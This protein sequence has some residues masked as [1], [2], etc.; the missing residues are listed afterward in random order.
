MND[1]ADSRLPIRHNSLHEEVLPLIRDMIV[2]GELEPGERISE[3][4]LCEQF[5][6]SRTPLREALKVLAAQGIIELLP[7]RGATVAKPSVQDLAGLLIII[8][9]LEALGG[10]IACSRISD[11][12]IAEIQSL[13]ERMLSHYEARH[14]LDYFKLNQQIHERIVAAA[15][16]QVLTDLHRSLN[17]RVGRARFAPVLDPG[18]WEKAVRE[19]G[20]IIEAL[21]MRDGKRLASILEAHLR[22]NQILVDSG[23]VTWEPLEQ[24]LPARERAG[25][26][27]QRK[28]PIG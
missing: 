27:A 23:N 6:I 3:A 10:E 12:E 8:S 7:R 25:A 16:V 17:I 26:G 21:E 19:H 15:D 20:Q 18:I 28:I 22:Y 5:G 9:R 4:A 11:R 14:H 1:R 13:H 24:R 2:K